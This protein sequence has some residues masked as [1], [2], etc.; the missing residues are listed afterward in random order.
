MSGMS[1]RE[2]GRMIG[3][4]VCHAAK[5]ERAGGIRGHPFR[6]SGLEVE[7]RFF[8]LPF[9]R[10]EFLVFHRRRGTKLFIGASA[11]FLD[12]ERF[13]ATEKKEVG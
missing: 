12:I 6:V 2:T 11:K 10:H 3:G 4:V 8:H 7:E 1:A 9:F 5:V 13:G